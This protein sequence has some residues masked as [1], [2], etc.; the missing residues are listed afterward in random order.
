MAKKIIIDLDNTI[1]I[2]DPNIDYANKEP[3][4]L[5]I[6]K[7]IEYRSMGF[8]III[9]TA[10]NM[11][12][13]EKDIS[14]INANTLPTIINWLKINNVPYDGIIVGKPWCGNDGF[15]VDD[16]AIRPSEFVNLSYE[17]IIKLINV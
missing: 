8:E 6:D 13:Y 1:T 2:E 14:K 7:L 9:Y 15:Y 12:S 11:R 4:S 10:R 5:L 17:D 16:K 3:N